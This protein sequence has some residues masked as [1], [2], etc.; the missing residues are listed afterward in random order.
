M[1]SK[2]KDYKVGTYKVKKERLK[3]DR[4]MCPICSKC[5]NKDYCNH[6]KNLSLMKKCTDC[7]SCADIENCD[8]FYITEQHSITI[9]VGVDE[10]T[11]EVI[12]KKFSGKTQNEAIYKAEQFKKDNPNGITSKPNKIAP[13]TIEA[14]TLEYMDQ[15]NNNGTNIDSTYRTYNEILNRVKRNSGKWFEKNINKITRK[16]VEDFLNCERDMGYAQNT[17]KKDYQLLK[18]AFGIAQERKYIQENYFTGYYGIKMPISIKKTEKVKSFE[19][20]DCIKLLKYLYSE[21][22]QYAHRDEYLISIHCGLRIGEVLA[23]KKE[24][25]NFEKGLIHVRRTTTSDKDGHIILGKHT[26]T[27]S[28][29]RDIPITELTRPVLIHAVNNMIPNENNLIFCTNKG[30]VFTDSTL[31]SCL[32]RIC[33]KIGIIDNAHNHKLRHSFSTNGI[34][35]GID[36]KVIEETMGHTDIRITM[37]TY[38]D[39]QKD[40]QKEQLQKYVDKIKIE[41]GDCINNIY[42]EDKKYNET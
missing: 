30:T 15:K 35:A 13:Q 36:Y 42:S 20:Q 1:T 18:Q 19:Y 23:L 31:N 32:K 24:D 8:K 3:N 4:P 21:D 5:L 6:R 9:P 27:P 26:K 25:I 40:F 39:V 17:L 29:E 11:G 33:K 10:T 2:N 34:I 16:E 37:D 7:S 14:I 12:R 41:L 28:G 38:T 22:F